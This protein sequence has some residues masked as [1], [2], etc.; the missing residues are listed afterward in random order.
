MEDVPEPF[1]YMLPATSTR[2]FALY[3]ANTGEFLSPMKR[4]SFRICAVKTWGMAEVKWEHGT[5]KM[6]R[7]GA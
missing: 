2:R 3:A 6:H 1:G 7:N 4:F 5:A